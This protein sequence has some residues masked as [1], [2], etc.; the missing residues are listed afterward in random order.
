MLKPKFNCFHIDNEYHTY[1]FVALIHLRSKR[2]AIEA[3]C[4][5]A[6]SAKVSE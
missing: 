6:L 2:F 1:K 5:L 3:S 4:W